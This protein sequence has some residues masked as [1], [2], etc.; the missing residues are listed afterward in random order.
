MKNKRRVRFSVFSAALAVFAAAVF[1]FC[2][3]ADPKAT[4]PPFELGNVDARDG[5][6]ATDARLALRASV[7]LETFDEF[8]YAASAADMDRDGKLS[9]ADA[10]LIL[11]LAVALDEAPKGIK[12]SCDL[13]TL[14]LPDFWAGRYTAEKGSD[15][16]SFYQ[17]ASFDAGAN[18]FLFRVTAKPFDQLDPISEFAFQLIGG[19]APLTV[20]VIYPGD[21][22]AAPNAVEE[23]GKMSALSKEIVGTMDPRAYYLYRFV[24]DLTGLIGD[25]SGSDGVDMYWSMNVSNTDRICVYATITYFAPNGEFT[26]TLEAT[27]HLEGGD[28]GTVFW[29][30]GE[31]AFGIG[32]VE[33][34]D[35]KIVVDLKAEGDTWTRT[36]QPIVF[37]PMERH[38]NAACDYFTLELPG[39]WDGKIGIRTDHDFVRVYHQPSVDAGE[40]GTLFC[41]GA[42]EIPEDLDN[43]GLGGMDEPHAI[44]YLK[45][46]DE[47]RILTLRTLD[48]SL[49]T[50]PALQED[51]TG[52][53]WFLDGMMENLV[54]AEGV[55]R[56]DFDY[57][58]A[59]G[60]YNG[61]AKDGVNYKL[62]LTACDGNVILGSIDRYPPDGGD[63]TANVDVTMYGEQGLVSWDL[64]EILIGGGVLKVGPFDASL[65]IEPVD[66]SGYYDTQGYITMYRLDLPDLQYEPG[67]YVC[68]ANGA[69]TFYDD[70]VTGGE[71]AFVTIPKGEKV[72]VTRVVQ[73]YDA[74]NPMEMWWGLTA[75]NGRAGY[76]P[77]Y[78]FIS[79]VFGDANL[80]KEQQNVVWAKISGVWL[81]DEDSGEFIG[82]DIADRKITV[83]IRDSEASFNGPQEGDMLGNGPNGLVLIPA[84]MPETDDE[85]GG[86]VSSEEMRVIFWVDASA[87]Q[88]GRIAWSTDGEDWTVCHY[89]SE[90]L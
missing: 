43:A 87:A 81:S 16:I 74:E 38:I 78:Y 57:S 34:D 45:K 67:Q 48:P 47:R 14:T 52:M 88:A 3:Y 76:V 44:C 31:G 8:S 29:N 61:T 1:T 84:Y 46:G 59:L 62:R 80:T 64:P 53:L 71:P 5:V 49:V 25:Y 82:F 22:Q 89:L 37:Y 40:D 21:S 19:E 20:A 6:T 10:R 9:A 11:R 36:E 42:E 18:G 63:T 23:Y 56:I 70:P 39:S 79:L 28:R 69:V 50:T 54:A 65:R 58:W 55:Q 73:K 15:Y 75:V 4:E 72:D 2:V 30:G 17:K 41:L 86:G 7:G 90:E 12:E 24:P 83:G 85:A 68:A 60:V 51:Y 66:D 35:G 26:G 32:S 77:L 33:L 13:F 27:M